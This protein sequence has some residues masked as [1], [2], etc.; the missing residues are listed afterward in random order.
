MKKDKTYWKCLVAVL[1]AAICCT[2]PCLKAQTNAIST[3]SCHFTQTKEVSL[4]AEKGVAEGNLYY[5]KEGA[6]LCWKYTAPSVYGFIKEGAQIY[7]IGADGQKTPQQQENRLFQ[8]ISSLIESSLDGSAE[9]LSAQGF[10]VAETPAADGNGTE[11]TLTPTRRD[12]KKMISS[13]VIT[14]E[15]DRTLARRIV[16]NEV[17]GDKTTIDFTQIKLNQPIDNKV[18]Q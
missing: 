14:Y 18:F 10:L 9:A 4:L 2:S 11:V 16:M 13:V 17:S 8:M 15:S 7:L 3:L 1:T 6:S 5:Q 12:L